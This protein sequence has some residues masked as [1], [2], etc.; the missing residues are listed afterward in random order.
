MTINDSVM[1]G[2]VL[3]SQKG[4]YTSTPLSLTPASK[5]C[6]IFKS[7]SFRAKKKNVSEKGGENKSTLVEEPTILP[8]GGKGLAGEP[9]GDARGK[10][11][12]FEPVETCHVTYGVFMLGSSSM[13]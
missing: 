3:R 13:K 4:K 5:V 12:I 1:T 6:N 11:K 2:V 7:D 10:S 8:N 9:G